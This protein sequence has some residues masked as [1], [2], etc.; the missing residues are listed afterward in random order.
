MKKISV[1]IPTLDR[2]SSLVKSLEAILKNNIL[3][4]EIIIIEQGDINKTSE[5]IVEFEAKLNI[6]LIYSDIKSVA[7]ARNRWFEIVSWD[8]IFLIDDD[9]EIS[10][11]YIEIWY[12]F[13]DTNEK[14]YAIAWKDKNVSPIKK[15]FFK[16]LIR[17]LLAQDTLKKENIV[18]KTG[19]NTVNMD[20]KE[21]TNVEWLSGCMVI[22][23][24]VL[25]YFKFNSSFIRWSFWEDVYFSYQI[26]KKFWKSS[27]VFLP[28]MTY[29][30]T[31]SPVNRIADTQKIRMMFLYRYIFWKN[32]VYNWKI[33]N[34]ILYIYSEIWR[35]ILHS[36]L[37]K[38]RW[39]AYKKIVKTQIYIL[40][41]Y[42][43][44]DNRDLDYNEFILNV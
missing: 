12:N 39:E 27:L 34:L 20:F 9:L 13:L 21:N 30:H 42:K 10:N 4:D 41:N 24:E 11:N 38:N 35:A 37:Y 3:P 6:N 36:K 18:L 1:I 28:N 16:R 23:K 31:P 33:W 26:F 32:E 29:S 44:I 15:S 43:K 8:Y 5:A 14:V 7:V 19:Q 2:Q 17:F 40:R 22:K 25:K